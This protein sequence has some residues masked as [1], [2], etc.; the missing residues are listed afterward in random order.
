MLGR[1]CQW[2]SHDDKQHNRFRVYVHQMES[3]VNPVREG[4]TFGRKTQA[5]FALERV[6]LIIGTVFAAWA[7]SVFLPFLDLGALE[8]GMLTKAG[9]I[10]GANLIMG[11]SA[12]WEMGTDPDG[13]KPSER[14]ERGIWISEVWG[15]PPRTPLSRPT[16]LRD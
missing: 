12:L 6:A 11:G 4:N 1:A 16:W 10:S 8:E 14:F 5:C 3:I 2:D 7:W 13:W 9:T 15:T